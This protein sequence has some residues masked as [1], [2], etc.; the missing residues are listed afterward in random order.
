M[1]GKLSRFLIVVAILG[2]LG[3]G[4][5]A[6]WV[7]RDRLAGGPAAV[8]P[9]RVEYD[10]FVSRAGAP[11]ADVRDELNFL[12]TTA[13]APLGAAD[14]AKADKLGRHCLDPRE[15]YTIDHVHELIAGEPGPY[16][17]VGP[18]HR[19]KLKAIAGEK[20]TPE[21]VLA[22]RRALAALSGEFALIRQAPDWKIDVQEK[23]ASPP[24]MPYLDLLRSASEFLPAERHP[25]LWA[26]P[27]V[28]AFAAG[29]GELLVQ[30]EQFF[31]TPRAKA[32]FPP[33]RF[34][35]VYV[36]GRVPAVPTNLFDYKPQIEEAVG[37][38]IRILLPGEN[39]HPEMAEAVRDVFG[40]LQRFFTAVVTFEEK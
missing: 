31:N 4:A 32:A 35:K 36:N 17:F 30:L 33:A 13:S 10:R 26:E 22:V 29:D 21:R 18:T 25:E 28:P 20:P 16:H 23:D 27:H 40:R 8:D 15:L 38:E 5:V 1:N 3:G 12:I 37:Q 9:E 7:F 39:P 24:P 34:Q 11:E 19:E 2:G 6:A 14:R